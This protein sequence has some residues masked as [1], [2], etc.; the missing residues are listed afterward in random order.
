MQQ[1][2]PESLEQAEA[3]TVEYLKGL[4]IECFM[5]DTRKTW[6]PGGHEGSQSA[7][8]D[9]HRLLSNTVLAALDRE[10]AEW[11]AE[12]MGEDDESED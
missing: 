7:D 12:N 4:F 6:I 2:T 9:A 10:R 11:L 8:V 1:A 5:E 3:I